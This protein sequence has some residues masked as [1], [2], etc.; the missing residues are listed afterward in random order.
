MSHFL[1]CRHCLGSNIRDYL[2]RCDVLGK[3]KSGKLKVKVYGRMFWKD[4]DHITSIRYVAPDR[5]IE[6]ED[7]EQLETK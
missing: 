3:T 2:M 6:I 1:K 4:T 5:V 7:T